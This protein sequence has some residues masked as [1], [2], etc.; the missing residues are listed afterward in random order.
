MATGK[1][2][3]DHLTVY[4]AHSF[5]DDQGYQAG[6]TTLHAS[7]ALDGL[8]GE[9]KE[10]LLRRSRVFYFNQTHGYNISESDAKEVE[11]ERSRN[12]SIIE[13]AAETPRTLT[14][15]ELQTAIEQ[16]KIAEIPNNKHIPDVLNLL[17][18]N[19]IYRRGDTLKGAE[20]ERDT[21]ASAPPSHLHPQSANDVL[22]FKLPPLPQT[23]SVVTA[24]VVSAITYIIYIVAS[25]VIAYRNVWE[26]DA[27]DKQLEWVR[28]YGPV[29]RYYGWFNL[30]RMFTTDL[31]ALNHILNAPE[32]DKSD[33]ARSLLGDI[34]GRGL[35]F[36]QGL[37]HRQQVARFI[38]VFTVWLIPSLQRRIMNPAFGLPQIKEFSQLFVEKANELRDA[39]I[40][41][42]SQSPGPV[43]LDMYLWLNKITLDI[44]GK[45]A[46]ML[47]DGLRKFISFDPFSLKFMVPA[48]FPPARL[49]PTDRSRARVSTLTAIQSLGKS[50]IS[51][52][53]AEILAARR[54]MQRRAREEEYSG[55]RSTQSSNE[56]NMATDIADCARMNEERSWRIPTFIIAGHETTS[57]AV[58]WAIYALRN[59][60]AIHAKLNAEARA[61]H[62]DTPTMDE[63]NGMTYL[64]CVIREVLRLHTPVPQSDRVAKE[65][66]VVPLSEPF[67]DRHGV[68]RHE[69][70]QG[71]KGDIVIVPILVVHRLKSLW[72]E[73]ADEF[74]PERWENIPEAVKSMPSIFSNLLAFLAGPHACIGYRFAII[75]IKALLFTLV[76]SFDFELAVPSS[77]VT[78]L[79]VIVSRPLLSSDTEKGPQLPLIL[80]PVKS[81]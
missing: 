72:G 32:F 2:H 70:R 16:G 76:R 50:L 7:G 31:R 18:A 57:I 17:S 20:E 38:Q 71:A 77:D 5:A 41:E 68:K 14:F 80:Q 37:K 19:V 49:I 13:S 81:D 69:F 64:D 79:T 4:A 22:G 34:L 46:H 36:V 29:F 63:L 51:Q 52:K 35:L 11:A 26:P 25:V 65:D 15:A 30:N 6:L 24:A 73:D 48:F 62:T 10:D 45:Q 61:F 47:T 23:Y 78:R 3:F 9:A 12:Q 40:A 39:L 43:K 28:E 58:A 1:S 33:S 55:A 54:A 75:E 66:T 44:I 67:I 60:P 21:I 42:A 27:Q 53:K 74:R 59:D 8:S 56:G